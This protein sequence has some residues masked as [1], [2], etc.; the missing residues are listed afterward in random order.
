MVWAGPNFAPGNRVVGGTDSNQVSLELDLN[1]LQPDP[2]GVR[3][4]PEYVHQALRDLLGIAQRPQV[5]TRF[6]FAEA[7]L[8]IL[9]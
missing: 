8:P 5:V 3:L 6:P 2:Q 1:T 4:T 7:V 9:A